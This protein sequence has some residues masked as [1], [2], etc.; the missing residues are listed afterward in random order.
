MRHLLTLL[1]L[2][3]AAVPVHAH[4]LGV[5]RVL[6]IEQASHAWRVEAK[7][8]DNVETRAPLYPQ[9]CTQTGQVSRDLPRKN[10]LDRWEF[11]CTRAPGAETAIVFPWQREGAFVSVRRQDGY[12]SGRFYRAEGERIVVP[13]AAAGIVQ[14]SMGAVVA[15]YTVL[16][17]E[18][19]L[20]G[21]DHLAFVLCLCL[22][23]RRWQLVKLVTA[24]TLGHSLTLALAVL[25]LV[26][27]PVPPVEACIAVSIAF[28]AR[29]ALRPASR[30]CHGFGLVFA[31]GLLHGLGF[32]SALAEN[33]IG[34]DELLPGLLAFNIG[35]E[36]GQ[37]LFITLVLSATSLVRRLADFGWV[38]PVSAFG[39]GTLGFFWTI[40]RIAAFG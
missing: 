31:F 3:L 13:L 28:V 21:W 8:P 19:I 10:R 14:R 5:A 35:V 29:E 30:L 39:L 20:L 9:G 2:L 24:F 40:E 37:L 33:G 38:R 11:R 36:V 18:H 15:H 16:G 22:I 1:L 7:L 34:R 4:D 17:V 23:A 32:A 26:Q 6:L 12:E 25:G 27:V